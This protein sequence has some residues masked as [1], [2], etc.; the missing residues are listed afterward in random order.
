M[1]GSTSS[2]DFPITEGLTFDQ[3]NSNGNP[4]SFLTKINPSG[5]G[6][7]WSTLVGANNTSSI[8]PPRVDSQDNVYT[9]GLAYVG[10]PEVNPVQPVPSP[11]YGE[12]GLFVTEFDPTGST[13]LFSTL[14]YSPSA[15]GGVNPAGVDVDSAGNIYFAGSTAAPDLPVTAG[16]FQPALNGT[17]GCTASRS[18][19]P[20][21]FIGKISPG[22]IGLGSAPSISSLSPSSA[23]AGGAAF[24][25][26]INGTNFTSA[27]AVNW[28]TTALAT[29]PM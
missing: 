29:T 18:C 13:L 10:Y 21:G 1:T 16:V 25:L 6:L 8:G 11:G 17:A 4:V 5:S 12:A 2:Y 23:T 14:I 26:T 28:G 19:L 3:A 15:G 9:T 24:T 22:N 20:D 7:V 27:A